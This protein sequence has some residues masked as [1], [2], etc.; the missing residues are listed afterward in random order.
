MFVQLLK[1]HKN[2]V[3]FGSYNI[4]QATMG[5]VKECLNFFAAAI[6][7]PTSIHINL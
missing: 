4:M 2:S 7:V 5:T 3:G 1:Q 6:I